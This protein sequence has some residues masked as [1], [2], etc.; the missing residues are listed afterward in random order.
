M[1]IKAVRPGAVVKSVRKG[2]IL[3]RGMFG[4]GWQM[5]F[6]GAAGSRRYG[7]SGRGSSNSLWT[8]QGAG[9]LRLK[10]MGETGL[11]AEAGASG[12][13]G[14][15]SASICVGG[16]GLGAAGY[17]RGCWGDVLTGVLST[18]AG[19]RIAMATSGTGTITSAWPNCSTTT[20]STRWRSA[21][22]SRSCS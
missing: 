6:L 15:P 12:Q 5:P 20:W 13:A 3:G 1:P 22:W 2:E 11:Q 9:L 18:A 8:S 21:R 4:S 7:E 17:H 14:A 10:L 16:R 19:Q